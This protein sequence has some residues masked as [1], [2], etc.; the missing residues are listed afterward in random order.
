MLRLFA[1]RLYISSTLGFHSLRTYSTTNNVRYKKGLIEVK[2]SFTG[3]DLPA[4]GSSSTLFIECYKA[5]LT[6]V[7][8]SLNSVAKL[9]ISYDVLMPNSPNLCFTLGYAIYVSD[10]SGDLK[11]TFFDELHSQIREK[12]RT[13]DSS[14][15]NVVAIYMK[16]YIEN[17]LEIVDPFLSNQDIEESIERIKRALP[18]NLMADVTPASVS[19]KVV[20]KKRNRVNKTNDQILSKLTKD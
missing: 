5:F 1:E 13:P 4:A 11:D 8:P 12:I 3:N 16:V 18:L 20:R 6:Y 19:T 9:T 2:I 14:M 17:L 10:D 7:W 15:A